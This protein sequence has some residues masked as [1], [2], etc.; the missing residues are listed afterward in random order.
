MIRELE[1]YLYDNELLVKVNNETIA[2]E[3]KRETEHSTN[4]E[5]NNINTNSSGKLKIHDSVLLKLATNQVTNLTNE[6]ERKMQLIKLKYHQV[7]MEPQQDTME[8]GNSN[9]D[10]HSNNNNEELEEEDIAKSLREQQNQEIEE[11]LDSIAMDAQQVQKKI[12]ACKILLTTKR[13]ELTSSQLMTNYYNSNS[14]QQAELGDE[15]NFANTAMDNN[16]LQSTNE[17][18]FEDGD[19]QS[20]MEKALGNNNE[21]PNQVQNKQ[22]QSMDAYMMHDEVNDPMTNNS[23]PKTTSSNTDS[24]RPPLLLT[25][26]PELLK[27]KKMKSIEFMQTS[28]SSGDADGFDEESLGR[29]KLKD[30]DPL[31]LELKRV[32][33]HKNRMK[34]RQVRLIQVNKQ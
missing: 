1:Q 34:Q 13:H 15:T 27:R 26:P 22:N 25:I 32:I 7:V 9:K 5:V 31:Y 19:L 16:Q 2:R 18:V 30:Q 8:Q 4:S 17:A 3:T 11:L 20:E 29:L 21:E 23:E 28:E 6:V 24:F 12:T 10:N 33:Q 14:Q